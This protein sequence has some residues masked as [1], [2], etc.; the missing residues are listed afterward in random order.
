MADEQYYWIALGPI[1]L[2]RSNGRR[3]AHRLPFDPLCAGVAMA[4]R[5]CR[6]SWQ[7]CASLPAL[8][9]AADR[10]PAIPEA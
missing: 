7:Q 2:L 9:A 8:R 3:I 5:I 4:A 1:P 10:A 6:F